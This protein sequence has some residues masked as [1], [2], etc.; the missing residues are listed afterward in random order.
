MSPRDQN[1]LNS[2]NL[3]VL[4]FRARKAMVPGLT[5]EE[6]H[7][8]QITEEHIRIANLT[9]PVFLNTLLDL[10]SKGYVFSIGIFEKKYHP[11]IQKFLDDDTYAKM[12]DELSKVD[13]TEI[14][15]K[16]KLAGAAM[17]QET[18]PPN[19]SIPS[20]EI[21]NEEMTLKDI[22]D[23]A[24]EGLKEY[25]PDMVATVILSPFRSIERLLEKMNDGTSFNEVK[26]AGIWYDSEK[27][28]FHFDDQ[29][30]LTGYQSKPNKEH[31]ALKALFSQ[32]SEDRI[33]YT[34]IPEFEQ[35]DLEAEKKSYRDALN[36]FVRKQPR[37]S[38]I[39]SVHAD[40]LAVHE[41]YL[42]HPH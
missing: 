17:L 18:L 23:S 27:Y 19:I 35:E 9:T 29:F 36:R 25:S 40:H 41:R 42:E 30:V 28:E 5:D 15:N 21:L 31:F 34:D 12:L 37:L 3:L 8:L 20:E 38:Q 33:D 22:L 10:N 1:I 16:F 26:D 11:E 13:T 7:T 4:I 14:V 32:F 24:R 2:L 39:F 6:R